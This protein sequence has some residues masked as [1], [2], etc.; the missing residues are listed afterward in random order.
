MSAPTTANVG[1]LLEWYAEMGVDVALSEEPVDRFK[2]AEV[3]P[4][5]APTAPSVRR[6]QAIV[7]TSDDTARQARDIAATAQTLDELRGALEAFEGCNLRLTATR[8][9]FSDGSPDGRVMLV[10]EGPGR[11]EDIQ[12]L[13]F[14]GRSGQLLDRMLGAIGLDRDAV[15]IANI[16]PWRPPGNRRPTPQETAVCRPFIERQ[17][18]LADPDFLILLGGA[19]A[20][21]LLDSREGILKLRGRWRSYETARRQIRALPT[22]HPAYLLRQPLHK[23]FAWRDFLSLREALDGS[24]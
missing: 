7:P 10:G 23:R 16:V 3:S 17:I 2:P 21:E 19:A 13:P 15:Y 18:E 12:G 1:E 4:T 20:S 22:L 24:A 14:V 5:P 6:P 8:M 9:V 11:D